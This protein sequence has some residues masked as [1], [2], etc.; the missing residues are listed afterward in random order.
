MSILSEKKI[1]LGVT[2]SVAA[3]KAVAL[4]SKLTQ[5]G[6]R[7]TAVLTPAA[8]KFVSALS[9]QSV[10][11]ERAY[12]EEDLWGEDAHI[13]HVKLG[14][15][16]DAMLVAPCTA[17]TLAALAQGRAET[18]LSLAALTLDAPLLLAPAMDAGMY[19]HPAVQENLRVLVSRGAILLGPAEG[20]LASGLHGKGRMLEPEDI[21]G[22]LRHILGRESGALRG[23]KIVVTAGGTQEPLDPVRVLTNRSSGKQ[24]Y[25]LAQAALDAG[26]ETVLISAPTC[27]SAPVGAKL[28]RVQTVEEMLRAVL[29]ESAGADALIMAAAGADF[30]PKNAA[31]EKM[32]KRD[33]IPHL[34]LE[35]APDILKAVAARKAERGCP[36]VV[37]G[38]AAETREAL[39]NAAEKLASKRLDFIAA[40]DVST[41]ESGF[42]SDTNRIT[43]L[44]AD[45]ERESLP[46]MKKFEAAEIIVSRVAAFLEKRPSC[47]SS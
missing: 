8:E 26:A 41:A 34:E 12:R 10:T 37:V 43:L 23:R 2:G 11:G 22:H 20:H 44:F 1:L 5:A 19:E 42:G 39:R 21:L 25:A 35:A 4:A 28:L 38:F 24:G 6:A 29:D 13:L 3:Y 45:G 7:V 40:N 31:P 46:L 36:R 15:E 14:R 30:R 47:E 33:G 17:N 27:L 9:F 32:K 16:A 18:L